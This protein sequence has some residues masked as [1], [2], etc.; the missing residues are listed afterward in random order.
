MEA[1]PAATHREPLVTMRAFA[2]VA[3]LMT[4][5]VHAGCYKHVITVG[6]GGDTLKPTPDAESS[7]YF[8]IDGAIGQSS[9][10][11]ATVCK[12]TPNATVVV[13][14]TLLDGFIGTC[15]CAQWMM[16]STTKV[17]CGAKRSEARAPQVVVPAP[18]TPPTTPVTILP[19]PATAVVPPATAPATAPAAV[20]PPSF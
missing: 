14:R 10:K 13:E 4:L 6:T 9:V 3:V 7:T 15:L 17:Y 18:V 20:A 12:D 5:L 11:L 16:P 2:T 19:A 8:F 1:G